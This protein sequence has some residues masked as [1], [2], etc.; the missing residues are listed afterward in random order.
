MQ[1][2]GLKYDLSSNKIITDI[3]PI[4]D[5][6]VITF[7]D[8]VLY[9]QNSM[10][11]A[12]NVA[13][14][15]LLKNPT[16][17]LLILDAKYME[18]LQFIPEND[19]ILLIFGKELI[20]NNIDFLIDYKISYLTEIN[21]LSQECL[22]RLTI[23][24]ATILIKKDCHLTFGHNVDVKHVIID[25]IPTQD[26]VSKLREF[27]FGLDLDMLAMDTTYESTDNGFLEEFFDQCNSI[28]SAYISSRHIKYLPIGLCSKICVT[29]DSED[30]ADIFD[31]EPNSLTLRIVSD[32]NYDFY[33]VL[34][35]HIQNSNIPVINLE[36][37][38][39]GIQTRLDARRGIYPE[40]Y[41]KLKEQADIRNDTR[42][43][44]RVK[45]L[46]SP[47]NL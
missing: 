46:M 3:K 38:S 41:G 28:K 6:N 33:L 5:H 34:S 47:G 35:E 25:E 9:D 37:I 42:R 14:E 39:D 2:I 23:V 44:A 16:M 29:V 18:L 45:P 8:S 11:L 4:A 19:Y 30:L 7:E 36:L 40:Y 20:E 22:D 12:A 31:K 43:F 21:D 15:H 32:I 27:L 26:S 1:C 17:E 13:H 24:N 10:K